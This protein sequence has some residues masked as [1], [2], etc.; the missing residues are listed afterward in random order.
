ME[1]LGKQYKKKDCPEKK[2][3]N[4]ASRRCVS[5]TGIGKKYKRKKKLRKPRNIRNKK[6]LQRKRNPNPFHV[7]PL[8]LKR[9][10][11]LSQPILKY[12]PMK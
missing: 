4:P 5:E 9:N 8:S 10:V 2:I 1:L 11:N 12:F 7:Y 6:K 3:Y